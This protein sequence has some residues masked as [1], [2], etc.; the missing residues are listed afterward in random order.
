MDVGVGVMPLRS[1]V[2]SSETE[3]SFARAAAQI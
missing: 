1:P 3:K 2:I